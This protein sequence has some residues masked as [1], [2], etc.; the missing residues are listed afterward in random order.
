MY[1]ANKLVVEEVPA[2]EGLKIESLLAR[3]KLKKKSDYWTIII[4][5][6]MKMISDSGVA[7]NGQGRLEFKNH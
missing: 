6:A 3:E 5:R 7:S 1:E 4:S 2:K